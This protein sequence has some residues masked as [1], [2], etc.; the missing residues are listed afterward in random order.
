MLDINLLNGA[1]EEDLSLV[2]R[3]SSLFTFNHC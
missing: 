3:E 1:E 2:R